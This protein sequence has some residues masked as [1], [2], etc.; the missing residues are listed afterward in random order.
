MDSKAKGVRDA[1]EIQV[2]INK[3]NYPGNKHALSSEERDSNK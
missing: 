1:R 2:K 3:A